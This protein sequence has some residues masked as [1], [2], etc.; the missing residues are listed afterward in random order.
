MHL[1]PESSHKRNTVLHINYDLHH[2]NHLACLFTRDV[3]LDF[4]LKWC[5]D[6]YRTFSIAAILKHKKAACVRRKMLFTI[7]KNLFSSQKYS[8]FENMQISSVMTS[9][10]KPNFYQI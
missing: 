5:Y 9:Y 7:F 10:T 1:F 3:Y 6:E 8:S 2:I 4:V